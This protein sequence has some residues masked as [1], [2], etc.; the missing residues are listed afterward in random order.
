MKKELLIL[1]SIFIAIIVLI[2]IF[3]EGTV[4]L[5]SRK[6][7]RINEIIIDADIVDIEI[8]KTYEKE[9]KVVVFGHKNDKLI[10][11]NEEDVLSIEKKYSKSF[12]LIN[13]YN[14]I[15][16]YLPKELNSIAI[17]HQF[18]DITIKNS[19]K[20]INIETE[21]SDILIEK[22]NIINLDMKDGNIKIKSLDAIGNSNINVNNADVI[23][24]KINNTKV[25]ITKNITKKELY[26]KSKYLLKIYSKYGDVEVG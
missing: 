19:V 10:L 16:I 11:T 13:C 2:L 21:N 23:I 5:E 14:K 7:S 12:C 20:D 1:L 26:K 8:N 9:L 22:T 17:K 4:K 24:E 3:E 25:E 6:Y 18:G 15:L